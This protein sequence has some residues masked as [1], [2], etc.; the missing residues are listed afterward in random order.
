MFP[1]DTRRP[2]ATKQQVVA[3]SGVDARKVGGRLVVDVLRGENLVA[4]DTGILRS[5]KSD[6]YAKVMVD[7]HFVGKTAVI[8]RSLSPTWNER[9]EVQL[10]PRSA[11]RLRIELFDSD[12]VT[13][14]DPMGVVKIDVA[15]W[16]EEGK[17]SRVE[18][19]VEVLPC[20]GCAKVSGSVTVGVWFEPRASVSLARGKSFAVESVHRRQIV[21]LGWSGAHGVSVDLDVSC[22]F[23]DQ[24]GAVLDALYFG[25]TEC[26]EGAATHGGDALTGDEVMDDTLADERI[27]LA[28][29]ALPEKVQALLVVVTAYEDESSFAD[30]GSAF[31]GFWDPVEGELCRFAVNPAGDHT[32]LVMC[33]LARDAASRWLFSAIGD[34]A[35]GPRDYGSWVP[36]L[37]A[38]LTDFAPRVQIGDPRDRV[39]VMRKGQQISIAEYSAEPLRAVAMGLRWDVSRGRAI[40]LDASVILL[41]ANLDVVEIVSFSNLTSL[42][43]AVSHSGDDTSGDGGGDDEIVAV[44]LERLDKR[45]TYI[46]FLVCSYSGQHFVDV[47]NTACRLFVPE[48]PREGDIAGFVLSS[49]TYDCT[50]I[51]MALLAASTPGRTWTMRACGAGFHGKV[52]RDCIDET[53]EYIRTGQIRRR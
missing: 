45:V 37:K 2:L 27:S 50:A 1:T 15:S 4:K 18:R 34:V 14:D 28:L 35:R 8:P 3:G 53:Q 19:T 25:K 16:Y 48:R 42:D 39:A 21:A 36:E 49:K 43:G 33:R 23:F 38:Y 47:D 52:A 32:G 24:R 5:N 13:N 6:P 12:A 26:F 40:D 7:A 29:A 17:G 51:L 31:C 10:K 41:D 30:V 9:F 20:S 11:K 46:A 44:Q 22:I